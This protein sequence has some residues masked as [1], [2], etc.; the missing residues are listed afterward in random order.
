MKPTSKAGLIAGAEIKLLT[1]GSLVT[2]SK[3]SH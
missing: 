1:G 3:V 2:I